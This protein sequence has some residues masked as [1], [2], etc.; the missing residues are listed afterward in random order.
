MHENKFNNKFSDFDESA[1]SLHV[2]EAG[3][4]NSL[5]VHKPNKWSE[6]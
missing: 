2:D 3:G 5:N 1:A 4:E 6:T